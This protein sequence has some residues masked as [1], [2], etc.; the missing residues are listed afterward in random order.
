[1]KG[2]SEEAKK[3]FTFK[4]ILLYIEDNHLFSSNYDHLE[5]LESIKKIQNS[6]KYSNF[7]SYYSL[8]ENVKHY[9]KNF[10]K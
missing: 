9:I 3:K 4:T 10:A 1:M 5:R 8:L 7:R 2:V 6:I